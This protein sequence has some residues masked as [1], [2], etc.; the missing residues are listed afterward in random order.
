MTVLTSVRE[1]STSSEG[2]ATSTCSSTAPGVTV[3]SN[4]ADC[5][6]CKITFLLCLPNPAISTE[7]VY[8]PAGKAGMVYSPAS[9]LCTVLENPVAALVTVTFAF[10]TLPPE[11][12][13]TRPD[14]VAV[15]A[16]P[17][18]SGAAMQINV[19]EKARKAARETHDGL[20][21]FMKLTPKVRGTAQNVVEYIR[22]SQR[23]ALRS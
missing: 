18:A 12:S 10:E 2:A 22:A 9:E 17:F 13:S 3:K 8:S 5:P 20:T 11:V 21:R 23:Q 19:N 6:T 7:T 15:M 4:S 14:N 1:G 16:W